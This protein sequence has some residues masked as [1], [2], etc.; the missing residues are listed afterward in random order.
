MWKY[1][2]Q[3]LVQRKPICPCITLS[4]SVFVYNVFNNLY[5]NFIFSFYNLLTLSLYF[6]GQRPQQWVLITEYAWTA[7]QLLMNTDNLWVMTNNV[8]SLLMPISC[9]CARLKYKNMLKLCSML[10]TTDYAQFY[11]PNMHK[12]TTWGWGY[13]DCRSCLFVRC[14]MALKDA[15][16]LV[17]IAFLV[18]V[19]AMFS[20]I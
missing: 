10:T 13:H 3:Y 18:C 11:V 2:P 4:V 6:K 19:W 20:F 1:L 12:P 9:C 8:K 15:L 14:I 5:G 16:G 17:S 7:N